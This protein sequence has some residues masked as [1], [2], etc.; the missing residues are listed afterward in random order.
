MSDTASNYRTST[1]FTTMPPVLTESQKGSVED[2]Q[3]SLAPYIQSYLSQTGRRH[4][5]CSVMLPVAFERAAPR[6]WFDPRFDSPVLEGQYQASVF[7]QLRLKFRFALFYILLCSL[8]WLLYFLFDGGPTSFTLLTVSIGLIFL[9]ALAGLWVTRTDIY[10]AHTNLISSFCAILLCMFSLFLL[11]L[12]R[13]ALSPLGHFSICIEIV[14][15]IYTIIPLPLWLCCTI[16]MAY[17][18]CFEVL[19]FLHQTHY[20]YNSRPGGQPTASPL[21]TGTVSHAVARLLAEDGSVIGT[22]YQHSGDSF[23]YKIVLI[24]VLIQLC[25]HL[26]GIQIL[27]MTV[28]RM[29]GTFM[30]VGQNLLVRRQLE[31]EKQLKEKMIHSMM[32]PKVADLLLKESGSVPKGTSFDQYPAT[33]QAAPRRTTPSDL[34]SLFRP[35]HMNRMENVSILFAD[36]VGFTRMSST[37]TAEQLV[38]ILNDLFERFDDL[39]LVNGCEKISTLG[40]C[41][42]CVSGCPEPRPDHAICCVEMGLGMIES[43]RVFDAQRNEGIKMRV[44]VHTGTVLCGIVGTKRVKFDVWSNDVTLANRMESSGKPDQVHVSE[45]TC[46]FLGDSY[47]IEEGEEVDG[48]RTYFV[49]GK[50]LDLVGSITEGLSSI[51][52]PVDLNLLGA[53]S[54]PLDELPYATSEENPESSCLSRSATNL[55]SIQPAVPP[56][57]PAGPVF[58]S[59]LHASPVSTP[60]P[61][62]ASLTKMTKFLRSAVKGDSGRLLNPAR[63]IGSMTV[64]VEKP[65]IIIS[66]KSISNGFESDDEMAEMVS[67]GGG[68]GGSGKCMARSPVSMRTQPGPPDVT[69]IA[70]LN[71]RTRTQ[72]DGCGE[73]ASQQRKTDKLLK[74]Q[75]TYSGPAGECSRICDSSKSCDE[76]VPCIE[77]GCSNARTGPTG[78]C[79]SGS[80]S[81]SN[82]NSNN[83]NNITNGCYQHV[84][85]VIVTPR[86]SCYTLDVG[87]G[88]GITSS[89]VPTTTTA[90]AATGT[91]VRGRECGKMIGST[92][93]HTHT[94]QSSV[95]DEIIDV[96]SYISQSRSDISPF[97][98][99]G[100]YRSQADRSSI[101]HEI[102]LSA[103]AAGSSNSG[104]TFGRPRSSTI[105]TTHHACGEVHQ[106][107]RHGSVVVCPSSRLLGADGASLSPSATS[108]KDSGIRSNSRRSSIQHQIMLMSQ[109]VALSVHRVSGYF[110]SSQSSLS[111]AI[112]TSAAGGVGGEH[113]PMQKPNGSMRLGPNAGSKCCVGIKEPHP[114]PLAACLQ[115][116]RKQSD[117]QLI[118]CVRDNARSQRSYLVK[119]PLLPVSLRFKSRPM[120]Q[121]FRSKAHRF[122]SE[123]GELEGG[124]PP[125]LATPKYNTYI[126]MLVSFVVYLATSTS[127]FL[128]SPSVYLESYKVWVCIF[129]F[130]STVQLF[131]LFICTKQVCRRTRKP[132]VRRS[133]PMASRSCYDCLLQLASNWYP[134]HICGGIL[135]S[136]PVISILSNFAMMDVTKFR[137]FEF[138]YGFLMYICIVHFCN[139]TQLNWWMRNAMACL[140]SAAFVGIAVGHMVELQALEVAAGIAANGTALAAGG[141]TDEMLHRAQFDWFNNYRVEIYVDL[142]LLLVLVWFLNRE[143]E[144]GYRL[145]FHGSAVANQDKIRVQNMKNQA[146]M[147]LHNII[148]KHVAEQLKNTAKYSENHHNI[149]IIFASIVNFNEMY[150]ESYLGGKEYLRVLNELIGDFDELL[151]RPEFRCVEKIKTIG[152]TFMAA[153][154][155][156]PSS[157]GENYEHL[158]TLLDFAL[159][160]QQVVE[161]FNRDLL[162]FNL[163]MRV[164][165]NFGDV[166]AG[167][168]G[169][170]K[171]Y[172][173]IWGDAVNVASRM[174]ST[175]VAGRVQ[176]GSDC[177]P[178]LG[179]R[180]DFEPRGKVYVKGKD[181]MEVYLL[182]GKKPDLLGPPELDIDPV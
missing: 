91:N 30:K 63:T 120:E 154:G 99:T 13:E 104:G 162:E 163:I 116:L 121:E 152:S 89:S 77:R 161:S 82:S 131:A 52:L 59:S 178:V 147:L 81:N 22:D 73:T 97:A 98:R 38:E 6:S 107:V 57:S 153:S 135:M 17:S 130:F 83:Q 124:G 18:V 71:E 126:D 151:A 94:S 176:I 43:I 32:P 25:V 155:L 106:H 31:M 42:Y 125:T 54:S 180:F 28:V 55:S 3:I 15:L 65:K 21:V 112:V 19:S 108:R 88:G 64:P 66:T 96:R 113:Q 150:D 79:G 122:G 84:P 35:F 170:S 27:I 181:H 90:T 67:G 49:L 136:L 177:V 149:G 62:I 139:F 72:H 169:T 115:Q 86:P 60:R 160:M 174:D 9:F 87:N 141:D 11:L 45:E 142:L 53:S 123:C 68:G 23:V 158:Y 165:Y 138:H 76:D 36:I 144:I 69:T 172:Y 24:R 128:L 93:E 2:I 127:L 33:A 70:M 117:L 146:D 133:R 4:S 167:V 29:R 114:D 58:F 14:M 109:T 16:T 111:G 168:I 166:T 179:E 118:R 5:C 148:P 46:G 159:A 12:T 92:G 75:D 173:D 8:V 78:A 10:R 175:G 51:G 129:V 48:H 103:G 40:D 20:D 44:G 56:A 100:S 39:C 134:W 145:S 164:G 132:T 102:A 143:F 156:D 137:V 74:R 1:S 95:F 7:P 119:P 80:S 61:R 140:T 47:T 105:T 50:K 41:Y 37:K 101:I 34:K 171:L 110:T 157:R 26:I 85:I 182:V